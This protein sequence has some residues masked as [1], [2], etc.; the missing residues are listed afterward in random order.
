MS[1]VTVAPTVEASTGPQDPP[2]IRLGVTD[3]GTP[4]LTAVTVTRNNPDG[5][6]TPVRTFDGNPLT[7]TTS[8]TDR[9][10]LVFD[11][12]A[13][14]GQPVTYSTVE[15][16]ATVSAPVTLDDPQVWLIH[17]GVPS[18]SQPVRVW[19]IGERVRPVAQGVH[20]PLGARHPVV[21]SDGQRK[22]PAYVLTLATDT[23]QQRAAIDS[24]CDDAGVLLLNVPAGKGWGIGAEYVA[25]GDL[26]E[27][28][29]VDYGA[30]QRRFW[31]LPC[32]VVDR[33]VGGSQAE[34]TLLDLLDFPTLDSLRTAY[35]TLDALLAGP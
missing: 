17:P 4:A 26:T 10:G 9:V 11:Y 35:A 31:S 6:T 15:N 18:L 23:E 16:P 14:L 13:P 12:E 2:R 34:R 30:R 27:T 24:L 21:R 33:P 32:T 25:V 3:T 22:A 1:T 29:D 19:R 5:T 7:L 8:G 28:R 20:R